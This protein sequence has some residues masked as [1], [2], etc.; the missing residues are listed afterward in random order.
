MSNP[1]SQ[2]LFVALMPLLI[3]CQLIDN[4]EKVPLARVGNESLTLQEL[5]SV[6]PDDIA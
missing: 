3:S 6:I 1:R 5:M 2:F 4:R